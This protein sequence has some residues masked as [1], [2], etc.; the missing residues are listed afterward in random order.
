MLNG[1]I[2]RD[3][4][5]SISKDDL[6]IIEDVE[7]DSPEF[8]TSIEEKIMINKLLEYFETLPK[9]KA[10]EKEEYELLIKYRYA[11]EKGKVPFDLLDDFGFFL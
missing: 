10:L 7:W 9:E 8:P 3:I 2:K 6:K 5:M 4:I 1:L 11:Y